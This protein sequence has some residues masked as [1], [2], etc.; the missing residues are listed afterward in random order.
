MQHMDCAIYSACVLE[1]KAGFKMADLKEDGLDIGV[2]DFITKTF[3]S[4]DQTEKG[5]LSREDYKAAIIQLFG[6]KPSKYELAKIWSEEVKE[7]KGLDLD[8]F[9]KL[10]LPRLTQ[11][12]PSEHIR[13]IF[14]AFDRFCHGFISLDDC[15]A[16]FRKVRLFYAGPIKAFIYYIYFY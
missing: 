15:K 5:Y 7:E 1:Q 3:Y 16:A 10:I 12:D 11:R 13:Q 6:Y 2:N 9:K 8:Q 4:S 14:L